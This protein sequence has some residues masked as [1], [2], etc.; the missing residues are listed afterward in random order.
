MSITLLDDEI[1]AFVGP[2]AYNYR[3]RWPVAAN[4]ERSATGFNWAAAV[5]SCFWLP[6]RKMYRAT[7]VLYFLILS[8]LVAEEIYFV[9]MLGWPEAPAASSRVVGLAIAIVCG[10]LGNRWYLSH[11]TR[12]IL[13][14]RTAH[15]RDE[16][17]LRIVAQHGGTSVGA[18]LAVFVIFAVIGCTGIAVTEFIARGR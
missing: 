17:Y 13:K 16:S 14:I 4:G 5:L 3:M 9:H 7:L 1:D 6:Y 12:A 8:D 2:R 18:A 10:V 11:A 15:P